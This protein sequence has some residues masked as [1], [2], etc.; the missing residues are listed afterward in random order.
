MQQSN[1][2]PMGRNFLEDLEAQIQKKRA[3]KIEYKQFIKVVIT[4]KEYA[5]QEVL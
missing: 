1:Q 4:T 3:S 2:N 5:R